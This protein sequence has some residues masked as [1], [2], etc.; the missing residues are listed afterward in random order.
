MHTF[1]VSEAT[2]TSAW[3]AA[4]RA[5][6]LSA[7]ERPTVAR[8]RAPE[9]FHTVVRITNAAA[10]DAEFRR[11]LDRVRSHLKCS[12][13]V[14]TVANTVFP[15]RLAA[16]SKDPRSLA[17]RY[18]AMYPQL[19]SMDAGNRFGTYFGRIV[20][21]PGAKGSVDQLNTLIDRLTSQ[22]ARTGP[23]SAAYE[24][25]IAHPS[26]AEEELPTTPEEQETGP[27][28]T[29]IPVPVHAAGTDNLVRGFPCL[30]HCSFQIDRTRTLHM[31]AHYR[32]HYM[33]ERAYGN[34]LGLGRLQSY[35]AEQT[36][37]AHGTLTV[38]AGHAQ[39][40]KGI[41]L[42]RPMISQIN[43]LF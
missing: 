42:I 32:S 2:T 9:A 11:E 13:P 38:T 5:M 7:K 33:L 12:H 31:T 27:E 26:D 25:D 36:G 6:D 20:A 18:R 21:Y 19:R 16:T 34:Y 29:S 39:I 4:C 24:L 35:L 22:A 1:I 10:D 17:E 41:S 28:A 14:E 37:L 8:G 43:R 30:S 40:E 3:A 15:Y 23:L